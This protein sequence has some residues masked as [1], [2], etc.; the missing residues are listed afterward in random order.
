MLS[1]SAVSATTVVNFLIC[2]SW[3]RFVSVLDLSEMTVLI[4]GFSVT[5]PLMPPPGIREMH[6]RFVLQ[7]FVPLTESFQ[8]SVLKPG[9]TKSGLCALVSADNFDPVCVA[10]RKERRFE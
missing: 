2:A 10:W 3:S 9:K 6:K 5:Q 4:A 8:S 7:Y 1:K